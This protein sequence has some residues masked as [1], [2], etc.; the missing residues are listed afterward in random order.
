MPAAIEAD[1]S[2]HAEG[3]MRGTMTATLPNGD[4]YEGPYFQAD[5]HTKL[6]RLTPLWQGWEGRSHW[7]GWD[8]WG[9]GLST[10][11]IY[12]PRALANLVKSNGERMRCRFTLTD[13][14]AGMAG[15]GFGRCQFSSGRI[16]H[17]GLAQ[18]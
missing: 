9:L 16:I 18:E 11:M 13:P 17:A 14:A 7:R 3:W 4:V 15:G 12:T 10:T 6:D 8:G 5:H 2:W 1:F